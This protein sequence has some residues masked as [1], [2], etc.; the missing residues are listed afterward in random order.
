[1]IQRFLGFWFGWE[2]RIIRCRK[3]ESTGREENREGLENAV[4]GRLVP[5]GLWPAGV[6]QSVVVLGKNGYSASTEKKSGELKKGSAGFES[7]RIGTSLYR[8]GFGPGFNW[9]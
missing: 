5:G 2:E 4:A 7:V 8:T 1:M 3:A 9:S 6:E